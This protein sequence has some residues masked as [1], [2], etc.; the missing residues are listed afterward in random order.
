MYADQL[1]V[2]VGWLGRRSDETPSHNGIPM[3]LS[4]RLNLFNDIE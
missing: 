3:N 2:D 4:L 1:G